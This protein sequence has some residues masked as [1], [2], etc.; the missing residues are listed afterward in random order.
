MTNANLISERDEQEDPQRLPS[1][2]LDTAQGNV[3]WDRLSLAPGGCVGWHAPAKQEAVAETP[4]DPPG[5]GK[6]KTVRKRI[7]GA[8]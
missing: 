7:R 1:P 8:D 6:K 2:P 5:H 3:G 4:G